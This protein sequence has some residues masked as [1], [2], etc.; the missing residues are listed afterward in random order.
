[1]K[2]TYRVNNREGVNRPKLSTFTAGTHPQTLL[3][4]DFGIKN[5]RQDCKIATMW[6]VLVGGRRMNGGDEGEGTW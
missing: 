3:N 6:G 2:Y 4:L 5:E 1:L